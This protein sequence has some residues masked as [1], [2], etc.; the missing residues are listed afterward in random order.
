MLNLLLL[1]SLFVA[2]AFASNG[3]QVEAARVVESEPASGKL[4]VMVAKDPSPETRTIDNAT[5]LQ[6]LQPGDVVLLYDHGHK[7]E[8]FPTQ[9]V[10]VNRAQ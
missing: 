2:P 6:L 10:G 1:G 7:V 5:V 4:V 9:P 3:L 8:A